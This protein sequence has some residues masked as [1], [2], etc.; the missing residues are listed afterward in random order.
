MTQGPNLVGPGDRPLRTGKTTTHDGKGLMTTVMLDGVATWYAER[1]QGDPLVLLHPGG[2]GV[3]ARA[4]G[5]NLEALAGRFHVYTPER[6]AHGYTP[7]VEGPIKHH[8]LRLFAKH[9]Y[10]AKSPRARSSGTS[11]RK[12]ASSQKV[13]RRRRPCGGHQ[14]HRPEVHAS[15]GPGTDDRVAE[16]ARIDP[17]ARA[18][19]AKPYSWGW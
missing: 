11:P 7:D 3:D 5:P 9:G 13:G 17:T 1:G 6:R 12:K 18:D 4:F 15:P 19:A 10:A 14:A 2:A 16:G 8:A